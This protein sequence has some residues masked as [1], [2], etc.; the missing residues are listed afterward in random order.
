[1]SLTESI[2]EDAAVE[3][4]GE[5]GYAV[6]HG[7]HLAPGEPVANLDSF[8]EVVQTRCARTLTPALSQKER[9]S[10]ESIRRMTP[11]ILF[12]TLATSH[13]TLLPKL[14]SGEISTAHL[15]SKSL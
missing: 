5:L 6:G 4:F 7:P 9:E 2:L 14:L 10:R 15:N 1:M 3:W 12:H 8:G 13:D 11:A